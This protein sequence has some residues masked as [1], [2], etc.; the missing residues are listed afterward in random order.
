M[1]YFQNPGRVQLPAG[2]SVAVALGCDFD[3]LSLW[4]G[5]FHMTSP[6]YL[7]RGE[8]GAEVGVPRLLK[9]Y[10]KYGVKTTW[11]IPGHTVDTFTAAC[12][13]VKAAGHE[14]AAH[15]YAHENP[16]EVDRDTEKAVFERGLEAFARIDVRPR[17]YRSPAWDF[18]P[19]TLALLEE[20]GFE[21]DSS[22]MGNDFH[23]YYPRTWTMQSTVPHGPHQVAS[24]G[25][26]PG[27]PSSILEIPV[28][29]FLD[30]FPS[31]E[32]I[33]GAME[34]MTSTA[35]VEARWR[36]TFDLAVEEND[37]G[38]F[39]LTVHPQTIGRA[40]MYMLLE[41]LIK[42][43]LDSGAAFMTL[44]EVADATVFDGAP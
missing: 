25:S 21:W 38:V 15:G 37:G 28:T 11:C 30:D 14:I 17:G 10:E 8:F 35:Q 7:S 5:T 31:Q 13:D 22:L 18:S 43:M 29:W 6:S 36:D 1:S 42:H 26:V 39:T 34:G 19:N 20:L 2:K 12:R 41:R 3:A 32:F 44:S 27:E 23:P 4:D 16:T 24:S 33:L 40:H 9:L